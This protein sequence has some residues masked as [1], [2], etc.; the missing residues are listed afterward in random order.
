MYKNHHDAL[1]GSSILDR[2]FK[3]NEI[4]QVDTKS[5][6]KGLVDLNLRISDILGKE[7]QIGHSYF[8]TKDLDIERLRRI[9]K[10]AII[11]LIEHYFFGREEILKEMRDI[12]NTMVAT[13]KSVPDEMSN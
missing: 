3:D 11:P 1:N 7:Y 12:C 8:M 2:W 5:I 4:D 6:L 9:I 13:P 10:Y